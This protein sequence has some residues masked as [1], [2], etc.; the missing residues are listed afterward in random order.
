MTLFWDIRLTW[1]Q[2]SSTSLAKTGRK[3]DTCIAGDREQQRKEHYTIVYFWSVLTAN[4]I[5]LAAYEWNGKEKNVLLSALAYTWSCLRQCHN[6]QQMNVWWL[7]KF[8]KD[9]LLIIEGETRE[10]F[11]V[12]GTFIFS[13]DVQYFLSL[14][15]SLHEKSHHSPLIGSKV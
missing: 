4:K 12:K 14:V 2:R 13:L 5:L 10:W 8:Q 15:L 3:D 6:L 1:G 9:G 11:N 7:V